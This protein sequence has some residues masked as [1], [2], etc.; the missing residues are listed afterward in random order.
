MTIEER[1]DKVRELHDKGYSCSQCVLMAY[2][3]AMDV[4][5]ETAARMGSGLGA[6]VSVGEIC[7]VASAMAIVAGM[8]NGDGGAMSKKTVMPKVRAL[9]SDFSGPFGGKLACRDLKGK[10]GLS[11]DALIERGVELLAK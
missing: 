6:G 10:C 8:R 7:G 4:D 2:A 1:K 9:L 5:M 3:D 11:C